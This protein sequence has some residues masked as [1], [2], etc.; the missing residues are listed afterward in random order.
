[1]KMH[2]TGTVF[3]AKTKAQAKT[4]A[5]G[6]FCISVL[7][8]DR[9]A[10][11]QTTPWLITYSGPQAQAFW[12]QCKEQL[13][14]PG[15]P[16][17]VHAER[18]RAHSPGRFIAPEVHAIATHIALAPRAHEARADQHPAQQQAESTTTP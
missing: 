15:Q 6:T 2:A 3:T 17:V 14:T 9:L 13:Q 1:M 4:A 11:H 16:L 8:Y 10:Q 18:I 7:V 5:D 12:D